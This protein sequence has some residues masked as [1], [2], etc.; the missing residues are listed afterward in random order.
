MDAIG[1]VL[2]VPFLATASI[3]QINLSTQNTPAHLHRYRNS[4]ASTL[5]GY[6]EVD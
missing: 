6:G 3:V 4:L 5:M 2:L 1:V